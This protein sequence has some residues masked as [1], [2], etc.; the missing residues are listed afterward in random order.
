[1]ILQ[2]GVIPKFGV[3]KNFFNHSGRAGLKNE[4]LFGEYPLYELPAWA[5]TDFFKISLLEWI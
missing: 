1:M 2:S 3:N 5:Q 4:V